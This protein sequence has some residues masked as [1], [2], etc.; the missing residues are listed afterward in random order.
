[1]WN[2]GIYERGISTPPCRLVLAGR[3]RK[4]AGCVGIKRS[5]VLLSMCQIDGE[6][7]LR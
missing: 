5:Y 1:M 2:T 3:A 4:S 6:A 7:G